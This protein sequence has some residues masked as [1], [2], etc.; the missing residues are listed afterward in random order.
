MKMVCRYEVHGWNR[1]VL[2]GSATVNETCTFE[3]AILLRDV[4]QL[5]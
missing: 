4:N 2:T 3:I 5:T 1:T